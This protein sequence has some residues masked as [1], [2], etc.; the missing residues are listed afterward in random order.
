MEWILVGL[1]QS[2]QGTALAALSLVYVGVGQILSRYKTE[3][4]FPPHLFA[5]L[6]GLVG[7]V[8]A[9][10]D[11]WALNV[12]LLVAVASLASFGYIYKRVVEIT[13]AGLLFIWPFQLSLLL[14]PITPH[15]F[16]L[17]YALL[18]ILV[19]FPLGLRLDKTG[20]KYALP[21]Y[22]IAYGFAAYAV[23][24]SL[25]GRFDAF[26]VNLE[27]IGVIVPL[28]IT[29][30]PVYSLYH[31]K[32][33][34]FAWAAVT[35]FPLAFG[36]ALTLVGVLPAYDA[37]AWVGLAFAYLLLERGLARIV[38]SE[39]MT[40]L[41]EFNWPLRIGTISFG[42][43]SLA[44]S[45]PDTISAFSGIEIE[46]YF[47]LI[48]AQT[49]VVG[50]T[51]LSARS[52]RQRWPLYFEPWITLIA[53]TLFFI[54]YGERVFGQ[55]LTVEQYGIMWSGLSIVHL[56]PAALLD[57]LKTRY[58]HGLFMGGYALSVL[59]ILW[60]IESQSD[61]LWTLGLGVLISIASALLVHFGYHKTW[62]D[63]LR[64]GFG[65]SESILHTVSRGTFQWLAAWAFPV[66][67]LLLLQELNVVEGFQWL[68]FGVSGLLFLGLIVWLRRIERSYAWPLISAAHFYTIYGLLVSA[69]TSIDILIRGRAVQG[70]ETLTTAMIIL[71]ASAVVFYSA[72]A[73]L[74]RWRIFTHLA[75]WLSFFPVTLAG[76]IFSKEVFSQALTSVQFAWL[77]T[78]WAAILMGAGFALDKLKVR[79]A[80][81]PY[82]FGYILSAFALGWSLADRL[83][84]IYTLGVLVVLWLGSHIL[85]HYGRHHSFE[86][87]I[88]FIWRK[89]RTMAQRAAQTGFLFLA[90]YGFPVWLAQILTYYEI[91]PAWRGLA[92]AMSAPIYIAFG[93]AVRRVKGEYTWPLYSAGYALTAIGAMLAFED[94]LLT[95]Y[96][97]ALNAFVFAASTYIFRQSFWLYLSNVLVPIIALLT[98]HHNLGKLPAVWVS[99]VFMGLAFGY[100][101]LGQLFDRR[102]SPVKDG[103]SGYA[104][105]FYAP[106]Y[107]LSA[108]AIAVASGSGDTNL[109]ISIYLAGVLLHALS[110]WLFR[111][112]IFIYPA[113]WLFAV[114]YFLAITSFTSLHVNWFGLVWLPLIIAYI[115][116]GRFVFQKAALGVRSIRTFFAAVEQPS[117]PF[118]LLAYGLSVGMLVISQQDTAV[119][120]LSLAAAAL[121]YFSSSA[122]FR[123]VGWIYPGLLA[124]HMA[125]LSYFAIDSSGGERSVIIT[126]PFLGVTWVVAWV[127][128]AFNRRFPVT[129][130]TAT[131]RQVFKLWRWEL[132]FGSLPSFGHLVTPS[133]AQPFFV[134][135]TLD[136][137][138]WQSLAMF[139]FETAITVA[140]GL[141]ILLGLFSMLWQDGGLAY[142]TVGFFLLAVGVRLGWEQVTFTDAFGWIAGIG[143]GLYLVVRI[144]EQYLLERDPKESALKVWPQPLTKMALFLTSLSVVITLPAVIS[145]PTS[146]ATVLGFGG[147]LYLAIAYRSRRYSLGYLGMAMLQMA[148][149]LLLR[150]Q[151]INEPQWYAIPAGLYFIGM[152]FLERRQG[153]QVFGLAVEGFGLAVLLLTSFMQSLDGADG[154]PY[155]ILLMFEAL[156]VAWWGVVNRLRV[157]FFVGMGVSAL[158]VIAQIIVLVNVYDVNRW[159]IILGVGLL[160]VTGAIFIERKREQ[161]IGQA[162]EWRARVDSWE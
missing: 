11:S 54:G 76:I 123:R 29:G 50:L 152:G 95:I 51:I 113:A 162:Q 144:I 86:D 112:A 23:I 14:S 3:Y 58:S 130:Q 44:L 120:A 146:T 1:E 10:G 96:V 60:T 128:Y 68:A 87:F 27:W 142:G 99:G 22:I 48:L 145:N 119:F 33:T 117:M 154:F 70:E 57:K 125:I 77:W 20:R 47:P 80:H 36:Q 105:P 46:D 115:G 26:P 5:Y 64:F 92:F 122:L 18:A 126:I 140:G 83:V 127:G 71:Q 74:S 91:V 143:F 35:I 85:V 129:R 111:E 133:W 101:G 108:L 56:V 78:G 139:S 65:K 45:A 66:W 37:V 25:V 63:F 16:S 114:P 150:L 136:I 155:F 67:G 38:P 73:W 103:I 4:R 84:N 137:I 135:T 42:I 156:L 138:I 40:W 161:I 24:A 149:V 17:A 157:P 104:L 118:Y 30:L 159:I 88:N 110:A 79:Y 131:D 34:L 31:F 82:L 8:L 2:W 6:L 13:L 81:G 9:V 106:G 62:E 72:F 107:L 97:L 148:W 69:P 75:S 19:Y 28:I 124:A 102:I 52:Y 160:L 59:A 15:A 41:K 134:F 89:P 43:I 7:I 21:M 98:L 93:L 147:A 55:P 116:I 100:T 61:L 39:K 153:R 49:L 121:V 109:A 12:S 158:N 151:S 32:D 132:D 90:T 141:A 94:P 53:A